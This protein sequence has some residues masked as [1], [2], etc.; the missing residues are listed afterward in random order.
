M[1]SALLSR[2]KRLETVRA[3]EDGNRP[4][5]IEFAYLKQL[6]RQYEGLRHSS[7]LVSVLTGDLS[8]KSGPEPRLQI[9]SETR[10]RT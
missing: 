6:P 3:V 4:L 9:K 5:K 2:V 1:R 8:T 10:T 7:R